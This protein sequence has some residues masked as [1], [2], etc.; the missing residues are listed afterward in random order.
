M[1]GIDINGYVSLGRT[2]LD[3]VKSFLAPTYVFNSNANR[4]RLG[5]GTTV[6]ML[7][8]C[9][10]QYEDRQ[11]MHNLWNFVQ[12]GKE[13]A[14]AAYNQ[15]RGSFE[16]NRDY[17]YNQLEEVERDIVQL[18]RRRW[19]NFVLSKTF[20]DLGDDLASLN[21]ERELLEE[22]LRRINTAEYLWEIYTVEDRNR[23]RRNRRL[24]AGTAIGALGTYVAYKN[25]DIIKKAYEV[26]KIG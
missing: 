24:I 16:N 11:Y 9:L 13:G 21:Y 6:A 12:E 18:K 5:E 22:K 7:L 2:A 14:L 19:R 15:A 3:S 10:D 23:E 25:W 4:Q 26:L 17:L 1:S 20:W 8:N